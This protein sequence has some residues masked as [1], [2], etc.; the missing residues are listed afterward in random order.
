MCL[1]L[2]VKSLAV[3]QDDLHCGFAHV[4]DPSGSNVNMPRKISCNQC[5][6]L[7]YGHTTRSKFGHL[8]EIPLV[9]C[10]LLCS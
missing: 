5:N 10:C 7:G 3:F 6:E 8:L 9:L 4:I 1:G 2:A